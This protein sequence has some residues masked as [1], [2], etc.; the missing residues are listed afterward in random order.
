[1]L[2]LDYTNATS[3]KI[4]I[5]VARLVTAIPP[6]K[7]AVW[8]LQGGP[9]GAA[10]ETL[11]P[12]ASNLAENGYDA[13]LIDHRGVGSS[14]AFDACPE[15]EAFSF[16]STT[17]MV[18]A[19]QACVDRLKTQFGDDLMHFSAA[20]AGRDLGEIIARVHT[21]SERVFVYGLSYGTRW[22]LR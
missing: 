6:A 3:K 11:G 15:L 16:P 7:A 17:A 13:Y 18:A 8:F 21:P 1:D 20:N 12:L 19:G 14:A 22:A 10:I 5:R 4:G 9:G 2:P